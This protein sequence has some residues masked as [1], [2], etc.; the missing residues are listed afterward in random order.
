MILLF[1]SA[2]G[3]IMEALCCR[4]YGY[5]PVLQSWIVFSFILSTLRKCANPE[6]P[7]EGS[8]Y[9]DFSSSVMRFVR[10]GP[11]RA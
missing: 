5:E 8:Y 2:H 1:R 10:S 4:F 9:R 11:F 3:D 6:N 7:D